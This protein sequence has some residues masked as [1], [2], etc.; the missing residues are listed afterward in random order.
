[1][2]N[3]VGVFS[4]LA[5]QSDKIGSDYVVAISPNGLTDGTRSL[6]GQAASVASSLV[7]IGNLNNSF[8]VSNFA[9]GAETF[10]HELGHLMGLNHGN[11]VAECTGDSGH[12]VGGI[13]AFSRGFGFGV[14]G[15]TSGFGDIMA[16]NYLRP[17][18]KIPFF[19]NPRLQN[20]TLCVGTSG[21]KCGDEINGDS[22]RSLQL[23]KDTYAKRQYPD[24]D[25]L[26]FKDSNF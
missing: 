26:S 20:P 14:C 3:Q 18:V 16:G 2:R 1:M 8:A 19:S 21:N 12:T 11:K 7:E 15:S 23:Y 4:G 24:V 13:E 25:N 5:T 17:F 9:C 10:A 6:C 22:S